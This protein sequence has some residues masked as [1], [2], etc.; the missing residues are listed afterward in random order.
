[1]IALEFAHV[2][3][4]EIPAAPPL[5]DAAVVPVESLLIELC[6]SRA[7][8]FGAAEVVVDCE[9]PTLAVAFGDV[10]RLRRCVALMLDSAIAGP[11]ISELV[12]S[13]RA[14]G[15]DARPL[16]MIGVRTASAPDGAG[17]ES[18]FRDPE[19]LRL[20]RLLVERTGGTLL[21][22]NLAAS[23]RRLTLGLEVQALADVPAARAPSPLRPARVVLAD[24][25]PRT[26]RV[27][28]RLLER[29]G[30]DVVEAPGAL[31]LVAHLDPEESNGLPPEWVLVDEEWFTRAGDGGAGLRSL[32]ES[33]VPASRVVLLAPLGAEA[34]PELSAYRRASKPLGRGVLQEALDSESGTPSRNVEAERPNSLSRW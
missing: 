16:L 2:A 15:S 8:A 21:I 1:M 27:A 20:A 17:G 22:S 25:S 23:E 32:V 9:P 14:A 3:V 30:F 7:L 18:A 5:A 4:E 24:D 13:A 6:R 28:R 10:P 26:R 34:A 33:V 11:G 31:A 19:E 12:V 29:E